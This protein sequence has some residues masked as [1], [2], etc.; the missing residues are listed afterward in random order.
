MPFAKPIPL[1]ALRSSFLRTVLLVLLA[2]ASP[3]S[4]ALAQSP[5]S[6]IPADQQQ[7]PTDQIVLTLTSSGQL[8]INGQ[9]IRWEQ[10]DGEFRAIYASRRDRLLFLRSHPSNDYLAIMRAVN[11]AKRQGITVRFLVYNET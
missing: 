10:L 4:L 8:S 7:G 1:N 2:A 11:V 6:V 9:I 5:R 3:L